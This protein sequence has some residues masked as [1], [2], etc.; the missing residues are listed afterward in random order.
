MSRA[1]VA[2]LNTPAAAGA[3][4]RLSP[5]NAFLL[6]A[7]VTVSFLAGSSAPTPLYPVYMADWGLTP[8]MVTVIFGIYALAVLVA[9]LV[10]GRLS[11]HLG[12]KPVLLVATVAQAAAMVLFGTATGLTGL[13]VARVVQGLTTGAAIGAVGAAMIDLDKARGTAANAVA[14]PF[15]TATGAIVAAV[16]VQ[17]LPFPTHLVYVVFG[18]IFTLQAIGLAFMTDSIAPRGS[19]V[20][21]LKPQLGLPR[22][23]REPLL[24]ALPVLVAVW[25]LAG[26]YGALGPM[27]VR[28]MLASNT[29][30]LGGLALFV[31]AACGGI[32]VLVFQHREPREMMMLGAA[33]LFAGVAIA[34]V[35]LPYSAIA[36]FFLGTAIAG[37]GFGAGFQ[38]A[39]RTVVPFAAPHERAGVLSIVFIISYIAMGVPAVVAG[40]M[41]ARHG[42]VLATAQMFGAVIMALACTALLGSVLQAATKRTAAGV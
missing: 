35:S 38:G 13:L 12:R 8:L 29:P 11:D 7:S 24:L 23:T 6:L 9:L 21:S 30:L 16:L 42:N 1:P 18:V 27:L 31:L 20:A 32:S 4:R 28:S 14:P 36:F 10:A 25:C 34:V 37:V 2:P 41:I 39:I 5:A 26:F 15:G 40:S 17:Y 33:S 3:G 19:V 22:A